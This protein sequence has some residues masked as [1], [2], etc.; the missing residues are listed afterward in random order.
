[1]E[2]NSKHFDWVIIANI[3]ADETTPEE[4]Q[5]FD[6][7]ISS[8]NENKAYFNDLKKIWNQSGSLS[9][10][11]LIDVNAAKEKV[12]RKIKIQSNN[13]FPISRKLLKVAAVIV[14]V[15]GISWL[16]YLLFQKEG[17]EYF[18]YIE[19]VTKNG[20]KAKVVLSNGTKIWINSG[21]SLK[22]PD[23]F[24]GKNPEVFLEGE[25]FFD[26][27]HNRNK[28][29]I[30]T[31]SLIQ[32]EVLGTEFNISSY[33]DDETIETT[34]VTGTVKITSKNAKSKLGKENYIL[35]PN[36]KATF[37]KNNNTIVVDEVITKYYTSWKDGRLYFNNETF[38]KIAKRLERWY[39]LEIKLTGSELKYNRYTCVVNKDK[40][41]EHVLNLLNIC[42]PIE[43]SIEG[44][45][46]TIKQK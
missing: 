14:F 28:P 22:Y 32:V 5:I 34:L 26:V 36:E 44:K 21:S 3:L 35:K 18:Q 43:Y 13:K 30:V 27:S 9:E 45:T 4:K 1:M 41:I 15:I 40:T 2:K 24:T 38:E 31:T 39:D 23:V 8:N 6:K 46:I 25:A 20:E 37:S 10:Y 12:K 16:T 19:S 29:F 17:S 11:D 7:W 33:P 42:T